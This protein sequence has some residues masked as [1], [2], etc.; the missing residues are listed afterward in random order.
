[1]FD[2][3]V[4]TAIHVKCPFTRISRSLVSD[5]TYKQPSEGK[6]IFIPK[7]CFSLTVIQVIAKIYGTT[8]FNY[9]NDFFSFFLPLLTVTLRKQARK[10]FN[11]FANIFSFYSTD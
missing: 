8:F 5:L 3:R 6:N 10:D 1:M 9:S 7:S 4:I 11:N 2:T